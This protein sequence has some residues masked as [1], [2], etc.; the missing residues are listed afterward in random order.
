[1]F[2]AIAREH[3]SRFRQ[4]SLHIQPFL[5]P[6]QCCLGPPYHH[7]P[8]EF[9]AGQGLTSGPP[10]PW[11][12][13]HFSPETNYEAQQLAIL[14]RIA[15]HLWTCPLHLRF[16]LGEVFFRAQQGLKR[17]LSGPSALGRFWLNRPNFIR[18]ENSSR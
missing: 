9:R 18:R 8:P 15:Q 10:L 11:L 13:K 3:Q 14:S 6:I 5:A 2:F 4:D 1:M 7:P 12:G 16:G 17:V